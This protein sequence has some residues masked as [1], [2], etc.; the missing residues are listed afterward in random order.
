MIYN[1][2][3]H[4]FGTN[5]LSTPHSK[6]WR[7]MN[8]C[9]SKLS[10]KLLIS[11]LASLLMYFVLMKVLRFYKILPKSCLYKNGNTG[12]LIIRPDWIIFNNFFFQFQSVHFSKKLYY[13]SKRF[14]FR[15]SHIS[16][17]GHLVYCEKQ[18]AH[19][20]VKIHYGD[21]IMGKIASQITSFTIVYSS[22]YSDADQ[23]KHQSFTSLAFVRGIHRGP[24]NSPHKW[25][26][27]R[28]MFP[29]DDVIIR[30]WHPPLIPR[31]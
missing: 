12:L 19:W 2:S 17:Q 3:C 18:I 28:K 24:V 5:S 9:I 23:R 22:V 11:T 14:S 6:P 1:K 27:T 16:V 21:V 15:I 30:T 7:Q 25:P 10:D 26:V 13:E 8:I 4:A 29:F 31:I 20:Q